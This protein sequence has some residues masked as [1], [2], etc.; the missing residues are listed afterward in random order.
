MKYYVYELWD[1][2]VNKPFYVGMGTGNRAESHVRYLKESDLSH[3]ANVI[4]KLL[5]LG[6]A[7][8]VRK[9]FFT[10]SKAEVAAKEIELIAFYGKVSNGG[11]L[12]NISNGGTG[13][14]TVTGEAKDKIKRRYQK[15][16]ATIAAKS[17]CQ[18]QETKQKVSA[19]LK[20]RWATNRAEWSKK[21]KEGINQNR[22]K[23]KHSDAVSSGWNNRSPLLKQQ[24]A[25]KRS[26]IH[27]QNWADPVKRERLLNGTRAISKKV[28]ITKPSGEVHY[29]ESL[30]GWCKANNESHAGLWKILKGIGPTVNKYKT[31]RYL[32]WQ[33]TYIIEEE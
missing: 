22:N 25:E 21:I 23:E 26:I 19:S 31:G 4:R 16:A 33:V 14:D 11:V 9:V 32:G 15:R 5:S 27:K 20:K 12:T 6:T 3:K 28:K 24:L 30:R 13:G 2:R 7:P 29:A 18:L 1:P 10:N 17:E 8:E